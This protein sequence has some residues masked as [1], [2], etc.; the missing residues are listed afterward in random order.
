MKYAAAAVNGRVVKEKVIANHQ[1][2]NKKKNRSNQEIN[3]LRLQQ[4]IGIKV[5]GSTV[6]SRGVLCFHTI[7]RKTEVFA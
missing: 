2:W 3:I 6:H 4:S 1:P 7:I 5:R